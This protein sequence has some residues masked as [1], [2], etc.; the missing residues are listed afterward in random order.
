MRFLRFL[1]CAALAAVACTSL[2]A[3]AQRTFS[4]DSVRVLLSPGSHRMDA[5]DI[6]PSPRMEELTARL[7]AAIQRDP[8]WFQEQ[9]RRAPAGEPLPYDQRLGLT[10]VEYDE[11]QRLAANMGLRKVAEA[12]LTVRAEGSRLV[13]DGGAGFADLTGVAI[14]LQADRLV[15]PLGDASGSREV[16]NDGERAAMGAWDGRTWSLEEV[17]PDGRDGTVVSLSVGRLRESGRGVLYWQAR[18]VRGGQPVL[19]IVRILFYDVP[20]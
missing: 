8:E 3:Q 10:R 13:F 5:M 9:V 1:T 20:R 19:R 16:H 18:Q 17:S 6:A 15:T 12:P 11:Y 4:L 2:D 7:Q 14:D